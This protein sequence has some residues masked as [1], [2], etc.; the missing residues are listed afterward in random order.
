MPVLDIV[1]TITNNLP[2]IDKVLEDPAWLMFGLT[3]LIGGLGLAAIV[4]LYPF[5]RD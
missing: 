5:G 4:L 1:D 3:V 2:H